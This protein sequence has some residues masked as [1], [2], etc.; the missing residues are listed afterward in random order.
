MT[1][2]SPSIPPKSA[3]DL[4]FAPRFACATDSSYQTVVRKWALQAL[5]IKV[6]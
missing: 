5:A 6:T 1:T 2:R 3:K 4:F